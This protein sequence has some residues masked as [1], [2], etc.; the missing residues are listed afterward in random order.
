MRRPLAALALG[1]MLALP[2]AAFA[3]EKSEK[4]EKTSTTT[5]K[6]EDVKTW[7]V[8]IEGKDWSIRP[9]A[10]SFYGDTG[11]FHLSSAYTLP[12]GK[13]SFSLF[14]DNLDRDPKDQDIATWA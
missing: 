4:S 8:P 13:M 1:G 14:R 10:P 3:Q 2:G 7:V 12:K 9:A 11:L 6:K 5:V